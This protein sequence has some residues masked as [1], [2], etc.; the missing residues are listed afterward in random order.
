MSTVE[1][2]GKL[3]PGHPDPR[4]NLALTLKTAGRTDDALTEY[5]HALEV[6]P[7]HIPSVQALTRLEVT[8]NQRSDD[9]AAH[10][11]TISLQGETPQWRNWAKM[12]LSKAR[13]R[14]HP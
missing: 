1:W 14:S 9:T 2:A 7:G 12:E 3:L 6:R 5:R 13:E 4:L 11:A 10:L 8:T